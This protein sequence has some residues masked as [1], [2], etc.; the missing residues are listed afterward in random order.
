MRVQCTIPIEVI[1]P[2]R[3]K[4]ETMNLSV[5]GAFCTSPVHLSSGVRVTCVI[6]A[7]SRKQSREDVQISALI[8]RSLE[9][10]NGQPRHLLALQFVEVP[11]LAESSLKNFL[12]GITGIEIE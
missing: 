8:R 3:A 6:R 1:E 5:G 10:G 12:E 11:M 7:R 9:E 4:L 2:V